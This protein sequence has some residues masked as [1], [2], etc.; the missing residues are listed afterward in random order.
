M[1]FCG[2]EQNLQAGSCG[3]SNEFFGFTKGGEPAERLSEFEEGLNAFMIAVA[4]PRFLLMCTLNSKGTVHVLCY[5]GL[6]FTCS[7][8]PLSN[9]RICFC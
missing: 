3:H 8:G 9:L 5:L 4:N 2:P 6:L 1:N 7:L